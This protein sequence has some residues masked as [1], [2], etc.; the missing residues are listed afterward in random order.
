MFRL[1][2]KISYFGIVG[3]GAAS[4]YALT[5][6][7]FVEYFRLQPTYANLFGVSCSA[8]VSYLGHHHLTFQKKG[9]HKQFMPRFLLQIIMSYLTSVALFH[10]INYMHWSYFVGIVL[11]WIIIPII[12]FL[13]MQFWTFTEKQ[14][15]AVSNNKNT[16]L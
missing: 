7:L 3:V 11:V 14:V 5:V 2:R 9:N 15:T 6:I 8:V 16:T 10:Y 4:T 1:L 12:N 13:L